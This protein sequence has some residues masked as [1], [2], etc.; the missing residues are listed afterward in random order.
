[1]RPWLVSFALA[2]GAIDW[3]GDLD[4]LQRE[5]PKLHPNAFHAV[6]R[7]TWEG[8]IAKLR[9]RPASMAPA[10]VAI[11]ISRLV[12]MIGDGHTRLTLPV[13]EKAGFFT[14]H[15]PT[16]MPPDPALH[17]HQFPVRFF[18]YDDGLYVSAA[19]RAELVGRRVVDGERL[20]GA[21][22]PIVAADN[23]SGRRQAVADALAIPEVWQALGLEPKIK[24]NGGEEIALEPTDAAWAPKPDPRVFHFETSSGIVRFVYNEIGNG[25]T[26]TLAA[27]LGRMMP[28]VER[29]EALVIDLRENP[30]GNGAFNPVLLHALIRSNR[31]REPGRLFVLTGRRTFSAA[32]DLCVRLEQETNAFFVGEPTGGRPNG[33]GD[34]RKLKLPSSGLTVRVSTLYWQ[35]SDPRDPR[36]AVVPEFP[37]PPARDRDAAMDEVRRIVEAM[38]KRGT[39]DGEWAGTLRVDYQRVPLKIV[40]GQFDIPDLPTANRQL[41]TRIGNGLAF[42]TVTFDGRDYPFT[43]SR[44]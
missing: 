23:D 18:W 11:E 40:G 7:E 42:G 21:V 34:S 22:A 24:L 14:G 38:R 28:V 39:L 29:N 13:P 36:D 3:S 32:T 10:A 25:K 37:A 12:A 8:T 1:M 6:S 27:F 26:E 30:G 33:Y 35:P 44:R 20:T 17:F 4:V 15:T 2:L 9:E 19:T 43:A 41:S 31:L 16:P 5:L